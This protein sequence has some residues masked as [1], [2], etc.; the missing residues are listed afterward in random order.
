MKGM[1]PHTFLTCP[2]P[3]DFGTRKEQGETTPEIANRLAR[4]HGKSFEAAAFMTKTCEREQKRYLAA[5]NALAQVRRLQ[6]PAIAPLN[7]ASQQV[8]VAGNLNKSQQLRGIGEDRRIGYGERR[9]K[10]GGSQRVKKVGMVLFL[11][12]SRLEDRRDQRVE[13][14]CFLRRSLYPVGAGQSMFSSRFL[15]SV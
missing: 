3:H 6:L 2:I 5:I 1:R 4:E 10:R 11:G 15:A 12:E 8:N 13:T 7:V 9:G 14:L